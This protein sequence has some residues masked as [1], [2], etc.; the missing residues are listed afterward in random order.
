MGRY[1]GVAIYHPK[2]KTNVGSLFRT[3]H[4]LGAN[5]LATIGKRYTLQASD[6]TKAFLSVPMFEYKDFDAFYENLPRDCQL[7]GIELTE[8]AVLAETFVHPKR[9]IYLLG[10]E[11]YG[12]PEKHLKRCHH[13]IRLR[14]EMSMN[15]SV[16]GSIVLYGRGK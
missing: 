1:F 8:G 11:D 2:I 9:A 3:A 13:V 7:I 5:F 6:T 15:V 4:I 16:A 10:A 12:I 14:G